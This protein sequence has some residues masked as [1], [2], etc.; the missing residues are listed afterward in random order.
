MTGAH[1]SKL[2]A[3]ETEVTVLD[4]VYRGGPCLLASKGHDLF[5]EG[6]GELTDWCPGHVG[7]VYG[8]QQVVECVGTEVGIEALAEM[9][10]DLPVFSNPS[11]YVPAEIVH[12]EMYRRLPALR[13]VG[14]ERASH[15]ESHVVIVQ[16]CLGDLAVQ[17]GVCQRPCLCGM[18][19]DG[20]S[21]AGCQ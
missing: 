1:D 19:G 18:G 16:E 3:G 11:L 7:V 8:L 13:Y 2:V 9:V 6:Q 10:V 5:A 15:L 17:Q 14:P 20:S 4:D 21:D 12:A